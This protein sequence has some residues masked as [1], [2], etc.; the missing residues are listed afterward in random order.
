MKPGSVTLLILSL[1]FASSGSLFTLRAQNASVA[2]KTEI[3]RC[4]KW[5]KATVSEELT[6]DLAP[7]DFCSGVRNGNTDAWWSVRK[8]GS[9]TEQLA[10]TA[11]HYCTS[12]GWITEREAWAAGYNSTIIAEREFLDVTSDAA[13]DLHRI[14]AVFY[15]RTPVWIGNLRVPAGIYEL[16]PSKSPEGWQLTVVRQDEES[17][18]AKHPGA[19]LGSIE[20]KNAESKYP[21]EKD[22]LI[23]INTW[24]DGCPG[25]SLDV[26]ARELHFMSGSTDLFVCVRPDQVPPNQEENIGERN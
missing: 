6:R 9:P 26:N 14:P 10:G 19:Y 1:A 2:S 18:D 7:A 23:W 3:D 12:S 13:P 11:P 20:M 17:N 15:S 22:L 4:V 25:P 5:M 24:S 21:T 8:C 16:M